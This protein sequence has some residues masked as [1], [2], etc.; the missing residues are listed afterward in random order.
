MCMSKCELVENTVHT[1][2]AR[3]DEHVNARACARG[4]YG[5]LVRNRLLIQLHPPTSAFSEPNTKK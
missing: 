1:L 4:G 2:P 5:R 3:R